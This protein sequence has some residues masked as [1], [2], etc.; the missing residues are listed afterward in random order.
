MVSIF[1]LRYSSLRAGIT[2]LSEISLRDVL[3]GV[4]LLS[5]VGLARYLL[6]LLFLHLIH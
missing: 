5:P 4:S 2:T 3:P 1:D 6:I